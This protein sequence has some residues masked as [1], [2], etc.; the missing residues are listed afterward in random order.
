MEVNEIR[1]V[2]LGTLA[3][4][5]LLLVGLVDRQAL[6]DDGHGWWIWTALAGTVLGLLGVAFL[7]HRRTRHRR[8]DA[9]VGSAVTAG[10]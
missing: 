8:D 2:A 5:V 6:L 1:P 3:W 10:T 4:A 7:R 9:S